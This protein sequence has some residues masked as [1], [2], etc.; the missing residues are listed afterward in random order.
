M[1]NDAGA[2]VPQL[3]VTAVQHSG[4]RI[5]SVS[6]LTS[7]LLVATPRPHDTE[8]SDLFARSVVL[9]LH[10]DTDGAQGLILNRPLEAG[11]DQ[12]L[13]GWQD[14]AS[15]PDC[16]FQGGPVSLD[17]AIALANVPGHE[18]TLGTRRLF[19][20]LSLVDLDAP[21]ALL[22]PELAGLRVFAGSCGWSPGQLDAELT[23]KVWVVAEAEIGDVFDADPDTL[24]TRVLRRQPAPLRY[25]ASFP[26]DPALN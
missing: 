2:G 19:G 1:Q 16:L 10:H 12:V 21:T 14:L 25:L 7:R 11:V 23:D 26:R 9:V 13:P 24:W 15:D 17:M 22:A 4:E 3:D 20:S 5:T 6:S 18:E 8:E